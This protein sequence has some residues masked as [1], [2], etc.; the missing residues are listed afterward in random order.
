MYKCLNA[1]VLGIMARQSELLELT[2][3]HGFTALDVDVPLLHKQVE[4]KGQD[5][6]LRFILSAKV[7]IGPFD[8]PV[9]WQGEEADF[10]AD[11]AALP[12]VL[13][14]ATV[15]GANACITTVMPASDSLPYHE[16]FEFHRER[17][18]QIA[19]VLAQ[20]EFRLG[21]GF[22]AP[23]YHRADHAYQFISSPDAL[24][25]LIK[26]IVADNLGVVVDTWHW[27]IGGGTID[28][29]RELSADQIVL[30]RAADIPEDN[31]MDSITE[32]LRL[33]PGTT[34]VVDHPAVFAALRDADYRGPVVAYP[35]PSQVGRAA[36]DTVVRS[37]AT[38][39]SKLFDPPEEKAEVEPAVA[40][41]VPE[42][43]ES[44]AIP[45]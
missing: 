26:T 13:D 31:T 37:A 38:A 17:L 8:L 32:D 41:V 2:L 30:V 3:S 22:L 1:D 42:E 23:N 6:A 44:S 20:K 33:M 36:R 16:N 18:S 35:H 43:E 27:R 10:K 45:S 11:L 4:A 24:L 40:E 9:R 14:T 21:L 19:D 28:Q 5:H 25:T 39:L 29:L 34:T 7:K 15:A 12:A